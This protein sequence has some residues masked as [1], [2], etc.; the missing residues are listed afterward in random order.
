MQCDALKEL[1]SR[2]Q[3]LPELYLKEKGCHH[4]PAITT[5]V[6]RNY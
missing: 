4:L 5:T 6:H 1:I 3:Y 2:L